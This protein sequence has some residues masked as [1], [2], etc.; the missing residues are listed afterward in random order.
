MTIAPAWRRR[1]AEQARG[2]CGYCL[3]Q[4]VVSGVPLT[5]EHILPI[6]KGGRTVEE[7]LW[8]SCRLCNEAKGVLTEATDPESGATAALFNPRLQAWADH[9][10]WSEDGTRIIGRTPTGRSTVK[11]LALNGELRVRARAIWVQAG[12]HPPEE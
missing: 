11:A 5:V 8:L 2:R 3:T 12:W 9:F 4:E 7:N 6:A 1:I 10:A